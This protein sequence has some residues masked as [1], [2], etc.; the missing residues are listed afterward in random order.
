MVFVT[1]G[2][3]TQGFGRLLEA[4][5]A[6]AAG[7]FF[8]A[9]AVVV[10]SGNNPDFGSTHCEVV[11]FISMDE[12]DRTMEAASLII[13][14]GGCTQVQAVRLGKVPVVMPRREKYGE[15]VNDHQVQLVQAL[16]REGKIVPAYEPADLVPAIMQARRLNETPLALASSPMASLVAQA[17]DELIG[18]R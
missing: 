15:H 14:H 4:V 8:E 17:I 10:Q 9:E 16:A 5:D 7:G 6:L 13:C 3:A 2:N 18:S 12:F 11:P 1:V